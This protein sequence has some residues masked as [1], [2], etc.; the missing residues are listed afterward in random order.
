MPTSGGLSPTAYDAWYHTARG[1]WMGEV[2]AQTLLRQ[3][4]ITPG[5]RVLDAGC[6][7]GWFSRRFSAAGAR[8]VGVDRDRAMLVT[9]HSADAG[10]AWIQADMGSLPFPDRHFDVVCAVTSLCFAEDEA[11]ALGEMLRTARQT[12]LLGLLHRHSLLYTRKQG[13]GAYAGA[14]W[15]TPQDT[16]DKV[17]PE[18]LDAVGEAALL[19]I[20]RIR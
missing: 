18:S 16:M 4:A 20:P 3:G 1:A 17:C 10:V 12:V 6:G 7:S 8:V 14:H 2:E 13:R 19:A 11:A 5:S 15:H 9:A